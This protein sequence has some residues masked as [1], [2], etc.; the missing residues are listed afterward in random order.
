MARGL[1]ERLWGGVTKERP[2]EDGAALEDVWIECDWGGLSEEDYLSDEENEE[3]DGANA[4]D[5]AFAQA[6]VPAFVWAF[7]DVVVVN[8][9]GVFHCVSYWHNSSFFRLQ[10]YEDFLTRASV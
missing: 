3:K 1:T 7:A 8:A 9:V 4:A 6:L 5:D 2:P 10:R